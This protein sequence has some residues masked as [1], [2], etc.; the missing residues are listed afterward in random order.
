MSA[1]I[2]IV[3]D[4]PLNVKLLAAKLSHEYYVVSTASSGAE[5]LQKVEAEKPDIVLLDVMMPGMDGFVVCRRLK[6]NSE[7]AD[8][9]VVILTA[10][11]DVADRVRGLQAGADD[12]LTKPIND[13]ALMARLRSL[14]RMKALMDEWRMREQTA[15]QISPL[16]AESLVPLDLSHARVLIA[17]DGASDSAFIRDALEPL[18]A[19]LFQ[20]RTFDEAEA[21]LA[22]DKIDLVF[23]N[24]NLR[25]ED[26]LTI[27]PRLRTNQATRHLPILLLAN[28]DDLERVAKGLDLGAN[29]YV[30]RPL[31]AQELLARARTQLRYKRNYDRLRDGFRHDLM[32]ALVDPLTGA[33]NR[34]YLDAHMPRIFK[35]MSEAKK[36]LSVLMIDVDFFKKVNDTHGH[37]AGDEV[38]KEIARRITDSVRPSDFLVRMGGEEFAI[39]MPE[40]TLANAEKIAER[41]RNSIKDTPFALPGSETSLPVTIS[42]GVA[43]AEP[44]IEEDY[45]KVFERADSGL[46]NAKATG[47]NKVVPYGG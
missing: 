31:D 33:F 46:C 17:D 5:A 24:L 9:P 23:S 7:T 22:K 34:R 41:V 35:H 40:A 47:R 4:T 28:P 16:L 3:D 38:L 42:V 14:L 2:L 27:C 45:K 43:E 25:G 26:G 6:A 39:V 1:R 32:L 18:S 12:F 10:L 15:L 8:I 30:L 36:P 21:V 20:V 11:T 13:L 19:Q 29:D 37:P 44:W